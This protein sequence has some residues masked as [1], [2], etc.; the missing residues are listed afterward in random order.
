MLNK[1]II[2]VIGTLVVAIAA[3]YCMAKHFYTKY[4]TT[5]SELERLRN[6]YNGLQQDYEEYKY[7]M[8]HKEELYEQTQQ[9]LAQI[10]NADDATVIQQLQHRTD[11][12]RNED[13][14]T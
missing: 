6:K 5:N 9:Q 2:G 10:A 8:K 12:V 14:S 7:A 13:S 4:K 3:F 1:V 11:R